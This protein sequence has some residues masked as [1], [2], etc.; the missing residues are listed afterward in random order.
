M[1]ER[2]IYI[3]EKARER[4]SQRERESQT[5]RGFLLAEEIHE[6]EKLSINYLWKT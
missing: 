2:D 4:K 3:E 1:R 5:V 6:N